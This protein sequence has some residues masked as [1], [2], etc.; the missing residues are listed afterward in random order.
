MTIRRDTLVLVLA[1]SALVAAVMVP[2]NAGTQFSSGGTPLDAAATQVKW[3]ASLGTIDHVEGP[4]DQNLVIRPGSTR[5]IVLKEDGGSAAWTLGTDG[6]LSVGTGL[7]AIAQ[8]T[9]PTDQELKI[10]SGNTSTRAVN[11]DGSVIK[12]TIN[13]TTF[14]QF[15]NGGG[16]EIGTGGGGVP[17]I[18]GPSDLD[19]AFRPGAARNIDFEEDGGK[20]GWSL[21]TDG[22]F[23]AG[24]TLGA[25]NNIDGPSD[26]NLRIASATD[27]GILLKRGSTDVLVVTASGL[28]LQDSLGAIDHITGPTDQ[29]L[30]I[31]PGAGRTLVFDEDGGAAAWTLGTDGGFTVAASLG[32]INH[33]LGPSD[34]PLVVTA[35]AAQ[36]LNLGTPAGQTINLNGGSVTVQE[37]VTSYNEQATAGLGLSPI[38]AYGTSTGV[39]GSTIATYTTG[40]AIE[41]LEVGGWLVMS[42]FT[43]GTVEIEL[44]YVEAVTGTTRTWDVYGTRVSG[45]GA[46]NN[47]NQVGGVASFQAQTLTLA[48][49]A[50]TAVTWKTSR[51]GTNTT[52]WYAWIKRV[53]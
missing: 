3:N 15:V 11:L 39:D 22:G 38:L 4:S 44:T 12:A 43:S 1:A 14:W 52:T 9:G 53:N 40:G 18:L 2:V 48:A 26:Q 27:R 34:Q 6:G 21:G 47:T 10:A 7:G 29:P 50:S 8:I 19:L 28:I 35:G 46:T 51:T 49:A 33:I 41:V 30:T 23:D 45:G 13:G 20:T 5:S 42:A 37:T 31:R 17:H 24:A 25:I 36:N 16:A 32:A